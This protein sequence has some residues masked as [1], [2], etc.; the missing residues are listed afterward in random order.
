MRVCV[1]ARAYVRILITITIAVRP[2][3][4]VHKYTADPFVVFKWGNVKVKTSVKKKT[5]RPVW[6]EKLTLAIPAAE[7]P[8]AML[9]MEVMDYDKVGFSGTSICSAVAMLTRLKALI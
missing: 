9:Q 4:H 3:S 8:Y 5:T 1:R 7:H 2:L 6:N